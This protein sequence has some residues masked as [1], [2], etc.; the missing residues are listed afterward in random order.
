MD[1]G[2][3]AAALSAG[4]PP[5]GTTNRAGWQNGEEAFLFS[6][7]AR[8]RAAGL[9]LKAVF[10]R[11]AAQTGRKP[12]SIR[13]YYYARVKESGMAASEA[14]HSAAFVPFS[15][16]EMRA[17]L[18]T[19]LA[20]QAKGISVRACTLNMG[21][22]DTK[23]MLRYQNKY[24]SL[25]RTNPEFVQKVRAELEAEGIP[26]FDPYALESPRKSAKR[27]QAGGA[28]SLANEAAETLAGIKGIDAEMFFGT[29]SA[30]ASAAAGYEAK[31]ETARLRTQCSELRERLAMQDHAL[32]A[33]RERFGKLLAL[34]RQMM[35]V[36]RA[37][38]GEA[39]AAKSPALGTY[40]RDLARSV[41]DCER[42]LGMI[43]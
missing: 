9:P 10:E 11:V 1:T 27:Q 23:T 15:E 36:N 2:L 24:R 3:T 34:F 5:T 30:L 41:E 25:I 35:E 37:F 12:N 8:G 13:N 33:Q 32:A 28:A 16:D 26:A 31:Q 21:K 29:L 20:E 38:L 14:F 7:V 18:R 6:E 39:N 19:V 42:I 22:G 40:V 4:A 17:L 43:S